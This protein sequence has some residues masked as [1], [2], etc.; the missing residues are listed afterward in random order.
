[1]ENDK[2][3]RKQARY[4]LIHIVIFLLFC[5][6]VI[7]TS[8]IRM[9]TYLLGPDDKKMQSPTSTTAG[10]GEKEEGPDNSGKTGNRNNR[11]KAPEA[12]SSPKFQKAG[13][14]NNFDDM[15]KGDSKV[16]R[17]NSLKF[18]QI[19]YK[20]LSKKLEKASKKL[21]G[22]MGLILYDISSGKTI[23]INPDDVFESASLVKIL[24]MVEVYEQIGEG[25]ITPN[26]EIELK[27]KDRVGGS[28]VL[29]NEP[30]GSK[31]KVSRLLELMI[32]E[33]DNTATDM[34]IDLVGMKSVDKTIKKLGLRKTALRRKIFDFDQIARGRDN[35][36]TPGDMLILLKEIHGG[37][38]IDKAH[39]AAMIGILKNQKRNSMIPRHL[40]KGVECAHKTGSLLGILHDCG[41][42]YPSDGN[43]YIL[44]LMG[45]DITDPE[46]A[47]RM[48]ADIS[49][50]IYYTF[51][52]D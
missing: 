11:L 9:R 29:K 49:K 3:P 6:V 10:T 27:D 50:A 7:F 1:M 20:K 24:I 22:T 16:T 25:R 39:R 31:W 14:G 51:Y 18:R 2:N 46:K 52:P 17:K 34:L 43:D 15:K 28:G 26:T 5:A 47:E 36:T 37:E 44:I 30:A 32:A 33:S 42:I 19:D 40:P 45:K 38:I 12:T 13:A 21:P 23:E 35:L 4:Y 8:I 41:I 48:F